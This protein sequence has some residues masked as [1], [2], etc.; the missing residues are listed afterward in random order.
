[1]NPVQAVK[2]NYVVT[3]S[4]AIVC[5]RAIFNEENQSLLN[6]T[7][8][9]GEEYLARYVNVSLSSAIT[10]LMYSKYLAI[11]AQASQAYDIVVIIKMNKQV[12][13]Q[14][15]FFTLRR[16]VPTAREIGLKYVS[17][18]LSCTLKNEHYIH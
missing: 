12:D 14:P 5:S 17:D 11:T 10:D 9:S 13:T 8:L 6:H 2:M 4:T 15:V 18:Q 1:M 3:T 7:F 16:G